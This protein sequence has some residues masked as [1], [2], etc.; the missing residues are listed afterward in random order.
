MHITIGIL[1][2]MSLAATAVA[3]PR[4]MRA[5]N[6]HR[7]CDLES[8]QNYNDL[9]LETEHFTLGAPICMG[10]GSVAYDP[11][12]LSS[13]DRLDRRLLHEEIRVVSQAY[14]D[15]LERMVHANW[16]RDDYAD[17]YLGSSIRQLRLGMCFPHRTYEVDDGSVRMWAHFVSDPSGAIK[18]PSYLNLLLERAVELR[19]RDAVEALLYLFTVIRK[20]DPI[21]AAS[22]CEYLQN[23]LFENELAGY[24]YAGDLEAADAFVQE[25]GFLADSSAFS[26]Y[27]FYSDRVWG[28]QVKMVASDI[29]EDHLQAGDYD[30]ADALVKHY[31]LAPP[32]CATSIQETMRQHFRQAFLDYDLDTPDE[33]LEMMA[34]YDYD[35]KMVE[36]AR[37]WGYAYAGYA[38]MEPCS[39]LE[40]R[41]DEL[42]CRWQIELRLDDMPMASRIHVV[43]ASLSWY[44]GI[45][46]D[47]LVY[48]HQLMKALKVDM[49]LVMPKLA[50]E[51]KENAQLAFGDLLDGMDHWQYT[52][53]IYYAMEEM[54]Y[55]PLLDYPN[56][57]FSCD[58]LPYGNS[59]RESG[60]WFLQ[61]AGGIDYVELIATGEQHGEDYR[62][63]V[64]SGQTFMD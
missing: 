58:I 23:S 9:Q 5:E 8:F 10:E 40:P 6:F 64:E 37:E 26:V 16:G 30:L 48:K 3:K 21:S 12:Y 39:E 63:A 52:T 13:A 28:D 20:N 57:V 41:S 50:E 49:D 22:N 44:S 2:T 55:E 32:Q 61:C 15:V 24:L 29:Y 36:W 7:T 31:G 59:S 17:A 18:G 19:D 46:V 38:L 45:T 14:L 53:A 54:G 42:D 43:E 47:D 27:E 34:R 33:V 60:I 11:D 35:V 4:I 25:F 56:P 51:L 1:I 62:Q